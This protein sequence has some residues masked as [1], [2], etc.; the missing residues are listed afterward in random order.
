[1]NKKYIARLPP[2]TRPRRRCQSA[3]VFQITVEFRDNPRYG[4]RLD[5]RRS[6]NRLVIPEMPEQM[7]QRRMRVGAW[8]L[9]AATPT[10]K[11]PHVCFVKRVERFLA[12]AQP[13][14]K[15][16]GSADVVL[17]RDAGVAASVQIGEQSLQH[18]GVGV[19]LEPTD[20][21]PTKVEFEQQG[22]PVAG[23]PS[24]LCTVHP[25]R[26]PPTRQL[27]RPSITTTPHSRKNWL[28]VGSV[29]AGER[30]AHL[31]TL[32]SSAVRNDLDVWAFVRDVLDQLLSDVTDYHALLPHIWK[33]SHPEAICMYRT[34]DRRDR[35]DR[36]QRRRTLRRRTR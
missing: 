36:Q 4:G 24:G 6:R 33:Q 17:D 5:R 18:S 29:A 12:L 10:R 27:N 23:K 19:R 16:L 9:T 28:F 1:M 7:P 32:V 8:P 11:L 34:Q 21:S 15:H 30:A 25:P 35:A 31:M 13:A 26:R 3:C 14:E 20:H 22:S 2:P